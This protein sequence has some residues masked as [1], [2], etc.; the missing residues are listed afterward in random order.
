VKIL[1]GKLLILPTKNSTKASYSY[2]LNECEIK[3]KPLNSFVHIEIDH[4]FLSKIVLKH[5]EMSNYETFTEKFNDYV[6]SAIKA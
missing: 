6:N 3:V 2:D 5:E 1:N 4:P